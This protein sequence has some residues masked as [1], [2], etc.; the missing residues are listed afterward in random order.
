MVYLVSCACVVMLLSGMA[1]GKWL[2]KRAKQDKERYESRMRQI[3]EIDSN[4][5]RYVK[6]SKGI[7]SNG[8]TGAGGS[9]Q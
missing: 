5:K 3:A 4:L 6:E 9:S 1:I 2:L 8:T 7:G